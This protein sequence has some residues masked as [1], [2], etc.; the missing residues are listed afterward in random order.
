M[1]EPATKNKTD[2]SAKNRD[3]LQDNNAIK[4]ESNKP[5]IATRIK[6]R[7]FLSNISYVGVTKQDFYIE[8]FVFDVYVLLTK[9][10]CPFSL[11][12]KIS[13]ANKHDMISFDMERMYVY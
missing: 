1:T 11:E 12:R 10:L 5:Y 6:S 2:E 9:N 3:F 4:E 7:N 8:N 13:D